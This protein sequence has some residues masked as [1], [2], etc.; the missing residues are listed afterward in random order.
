VGASVIAK[1]LV[2]VLLGANWTIATPFV[3]LLAIHAA[4]WS[5]VESMQPYFMVTNRERLLRAQ[6][7]LQALKHLAKT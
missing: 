1:E 7:V 6:K 4:F 5:I 2:L 3:Q